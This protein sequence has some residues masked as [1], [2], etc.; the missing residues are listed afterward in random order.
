M[1]GS[2]DNTKPPGADLVARVL[3]HFEHAVVLILMAL[4]M[5][6]TTVCTLELGWLLVIDL[7][8]GALLPLDVEE[9]FEIFGFFLLVLIGLELLSTLKSYLF[10][11]VIHVE[12]VLEVA[13]IAIAQKVI[14][15]DMGKTDG[16]S[17]VGLAGLV[18]ALSAAFWG[19][20]KARGATRDNQPKGP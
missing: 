15:L 18:G 19:V 17:L 7:G 12:I 1:A 11:R 2:T 16:L 10:E 4:L 6:V 14:I 9:T 13:L 5:V 20:R 3:R 8:T